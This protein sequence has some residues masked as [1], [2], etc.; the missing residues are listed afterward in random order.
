VSKRRQDDTVHVTGSLQA[1][2]DG[3]LSDAAAERVHAHCRSCPACDEA[4]RGLQQAWQALAAIEAPSLQRSLWPGIGARLRARR[5]P[6]AW[7]RLAVAGSATFSL[8]F[9][10]YL[11]LHLGGPPRAW[12][13]TDSPDAS[14]L[15]QGVALVESGAPT[16]D[17][18]Y[19]ALWNP[20]SAQVA[21]EQIG[22]EEATQ[23]P[24]SPASPGT[25]QPR[26]DGR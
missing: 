1:W 25:D 14:L 17:R 7:S 5:R 21:G 12:Q 11:G 16:L 3:E 23:P 15:E 4:R 13:G 20:Q 2:L 26:E 19:L 18:L 8:F 22:V 6:A 10:L 24:S 9:G